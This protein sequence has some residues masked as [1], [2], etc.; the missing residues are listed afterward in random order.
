MN[1]QSKSCGCVGFESMR[2]KN[3]LPLG[4]S[5]RNAVLGRY[6]KEARDRKYTW[7]LTNE[8]FYNITKSNC[9]YCGIKPLGEAHS[10]N[11]SFIYNG[12]DRVN[13]LIGYVLSN[14][15]ACCKDCNLAKYKK[16]T[17]QF[18]EY[19]N[20]VYNHQRYKDSIK[21]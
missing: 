18:L 15:V 8:E 16:I 4:I 9:Y 11:G 1:G 5:A 19:I 12:I 17:D 7:E 21:Q 13:N 10:R 6:K 20:R 14:V 2:I 3:S